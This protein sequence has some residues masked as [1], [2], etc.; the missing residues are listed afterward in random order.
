MS[1]LKTPFGAMM[2]QLSPFFI[3]F[4]ISGFILMIGLLLI[5]YPLLKNQY[6]C[7]L[8]NSMKK[9]NTKEKQLDMIISP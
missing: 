8:K 7:L 4:F 5:I 9:N 6:Y 1:T 3:L 2:K